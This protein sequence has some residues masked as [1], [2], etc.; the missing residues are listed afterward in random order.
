M[1]SK[2]PSSQKTES[3]VDILKAHIDEL[4]IKHLGD[5]WINENK[6]ELGPLMEDQDS[7][8]RSS[9]VYRNV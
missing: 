7:R 3:S 6:V 1:G 2:S 8:I 9:P 4:S 5:D